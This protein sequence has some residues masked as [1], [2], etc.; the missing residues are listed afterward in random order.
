[1]GFGAVSPIRRSWVRPVSDAT[2]AAYGADPAPPPQQSVP[3]PGR[4][5]LIRLQLSPDAPG[6]RSVGTAGALADLSFE[7]LIRDV[8]PGQL[9]AAQICPLLWDEADALEWVRGWFD[10]LAP[11]FGAA[12]QA[13]EAMLVWV[14]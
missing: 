12:A 6:H 5:K 3:A 13:G 11:F 14:D 8:D 10:P 2:P 1:M 4:G 9:T 7:G